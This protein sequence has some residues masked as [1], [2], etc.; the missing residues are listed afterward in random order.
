MEKNEEVAKGN[1]FYQDITSVPII[2]ATLM[3]LYFGISFAVNGD[4]GNKGYMNIL[5]LP[6]SAAFASA[7]G[8]ISTSLQFSKS[9]KLQSFI[10]PIIIVMSA[11]SIDF[12]ANFSNNVFILTFILVGFASILLS[13]SNRIE[14]NNLL[15]STVIGFHLA[16]SYASSLTF[17]PGLDVDSQRTDIGIAFISFWLAS[18]SIG[19]TLVGFLKGVVDKVGKSPFFADIPIFKE[20]KSFVI[21]SSIISI[22]Y[23]IPLFRYDSF[24]SLGVIWAVSTSVIILFYAYCYF[25]K[26]HVLGSM[27]LVNWFI[28]TMAHLQ[29]I[30][31]NFYPD[32]FEEESFTGAFS[33]FFITFWLN[34]G[35]IILSS[36]GFF[37]DI[38][39][40]RSRSKLRMW[41]DSNYY[42]ILIPISLSLIHI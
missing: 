27:I 17:D 36:K 34:V 18:I 19:F 9:N 38:A 29:E 26:W 6:L 21:F 11:L 42:S 8:R 13:N 25:E 39:P 40:S 14:E 7:I 24:E 33:W 5:I 16:I 1:F 10:I 22:V 28:F 3:V 2:L 20:N 12:I 15:L 32:I 35:A 41:W 37:G 30:G 23:I 4:I 31:N